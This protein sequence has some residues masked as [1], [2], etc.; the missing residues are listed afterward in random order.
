MLSIEHMKIEHV[1][2]KKL[3]DN[4]DYLTTGVLAGD[5]WRL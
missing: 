1:G 3:L 2:F 5:G 4:V